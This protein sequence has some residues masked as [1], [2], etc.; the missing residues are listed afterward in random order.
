[1]SVKGKA[2]FFAYKLLSRNMYLKLTYFYYHKKFLNIKCPKRLSEKLY[3]LKIYNGRIH[4]ELI[5]R[6]YDKY[7][8]RDFVKETVGEKY[9]TKLYGVWKSAK[10]INFSKLPEKCIFKISQS[11]G[12]NL[13]CMKGYK[14]KEY[15]IKTQLDAWLLEQNSAEAAD[16]IS[17]YEAYCYTQNS[18]IICEELLE[19][20]ENH[21]PDDIRIYC[22]NGKAEFVT[23]DYD[24]VSK[25]GE[26]RHDYPRNVFDINGNFID[27]E[28][29][30]RNDSTRGFPQI[31]NY[32]EMLS[33]S[34]ELA[35]P[36]EFARIDLYNIRGRIIFGEITWIPMGGAGTV[37]PDSFDLEMGEKLKIPNLVEIIER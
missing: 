24:S 15:E 3:L 6:C 5:K 13:I 11:S 34:E 35:K 31:E 37:K 20:S 8:V 30:R 25:N 32:K 18:V 28:L 12:C 19:S 4:G 36:F 22:F 21:I 14:E 9:L 33:V 7:T 10:E 27:A 29:G 17:K 16:E 26:K 23:I 1:M 2:N